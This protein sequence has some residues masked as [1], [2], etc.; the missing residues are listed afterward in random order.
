MKKFILR[1]IPVILVGILMLANFSTVSAAWD[2]L[3]NGSL[4]N[5][6]MNNIETGVSKVWNTVT[7]VLQVLA[8]A[9]IVFAGVKYMFASAEGKADIKTGMLGLVIGAILVFGAST[10]IKV[11]LKAQQDV[12]NGLT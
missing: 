2:P 5:D 7:S 3:N 11:V 9:A 12:T 4:T 8:I 10:I 6:S 1:A